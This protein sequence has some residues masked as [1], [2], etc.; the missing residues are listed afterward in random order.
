MT[1]RNTH[2]ALAWLK[3]DR[4]S[5]NR[6]WHAKCLIRVRSARNIP[7]LYPSAF[8]AQHAT[9]MS[10][11]IYDIT[12]VTQGMIGFAD[13]PNDGNPYG[14][15][16]TFIGRNKAGT[17]IVDTNDALIDGAGCVVEYDWFKPHWGDSFQFASTSCNGVSLDLPGAPKPKHPKPKH[18]NPTGFEL[19]NV[20][21]AIHRLEKSIVWHQK[22]H[23]N[24]VAAALKIDVAHLNNT[25]NRFKKGGK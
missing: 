9:P 3:A 4:A 24:A 19:V 17:P 6:S 22:H 20:Q 25:L 23:D 5:G 7:A 13:D 10:E 16:F 14:H 15:V 21:Y 11:R 1:Q 18:P 2:E 8:A 12:K